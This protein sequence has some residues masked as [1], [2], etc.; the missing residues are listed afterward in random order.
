VKNHQ[1]FG[2][3]KILDRAAAPGEIPAKPWCY[4][5]PR[6]SSTSQIHCVF[7]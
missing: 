4:I 2:P 1:R 7:F 5:F 3:A 6:L